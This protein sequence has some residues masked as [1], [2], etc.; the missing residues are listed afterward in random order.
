[1]NSRIP[2]T[3]IFLELFEAPASTA[4]PLPPGTEVVREDAIDAAT[5]LSLY[6]EV[7]A[8]WLWYERSDLGERELQSLLDDPAVSV[9]TLRV[10]DHRA[11]YVEYQRKSADEIQILYFGL[12]PAYIGRGLGPAFLDWSVRRAFDEGTRRLWLHTCTLDHPRALGTYQ[13]LGFREYKRESGWV[14]IPTRA[15]E[16]QRSAGK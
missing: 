6:D 4:R 12:A 8:P 11:G 5:Y 1:M 15:F 10:D 3:T 13:D 9:Y 7:G 2:V 14:R 16:R